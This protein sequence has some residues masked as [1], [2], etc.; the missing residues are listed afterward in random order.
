MRQYAEVSVTT[1]IGNIVLLSMAM[2]WSNV[3]LPPYN[4][5]HIRVVEDQADA[6]RAVDQYDEQATKPIQAGAD[7]H[8]DVTA[9]AQRPG[10]RAALTPVHYEQIA[11]L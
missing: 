10:A 1:V 6:K 3:M 2:S 8:E 5:R 7:W 11:R 4:E 9:A